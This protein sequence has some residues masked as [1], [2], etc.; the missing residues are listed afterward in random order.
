MFPSERCRALSP[1]RYSREP[2][3]PYG[4]GTKR[5][6]VSSGRWQYPRVTPSPPMY[7]S[8]ATPDGT[9]FSAPSSTYIR[10]FAKGFPIGTSRLSPAPSASLS[11]HV[12]SIVVSLMPYELMRR[13]L[14]PITPRMRRYSFTYQAS[15]PAMSTFIASSRCPVSSRCCN[16][17][18]S[19]AGTNSAQSTASASISPCSFPGSSSHSRG[20]STSL[21][22]EHSA[23]DK[24][25]PKT[26]KEKLAICRWLRHASFSP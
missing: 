2:G 10:T 1:E 17:P 18:R 4:L 11:N 12:L 25:P 26:S 23:R 14:A 13:V 3:G 15:E 24:S 5:S 8:L 22:P 6:A 21:P 19:T 7:S 20:L 16:S 9:G